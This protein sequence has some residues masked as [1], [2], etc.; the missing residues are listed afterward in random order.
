MNDMVAYL[1]FLSR[2]V[3]GGSEPIP[4]RMPP[5]PALRGDSGAG[6]GLYVQHCARCHAPDGAGTPIA[7]AL[8]GERSFSIGA[9]M[10]RPERAAAFIR[11]NMPFDTPGVLSDQQAFDVAAYV[12]SHPRPDLPWKADDWPRG[13]APADVPYATRGGH[14]P[15]HAP[16]LLRRTPPR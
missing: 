15:T 4:I 3:P 5:M 14:V 10:A 16:P 8:W 2:G 11:S 6:A 7:P 9:S 13:D 1:A 12:T